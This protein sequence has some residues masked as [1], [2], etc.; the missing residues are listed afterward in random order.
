MVFP[1]KIDILQQWL[2]CRRVASHHVTRAIWWKNEI[3]M[4][5]PD[6]V[7]RPCRNTGCLSPWTAE[8]IWLWVKT[9]AP[10]RYPKIR[11]IFFKWIYIHEYNRLICIYIYKI[12]IMRV[13]NMRHLHISLSLSL[14]LSLHFLLKEFSRDKG[15]LHIYCILGWSFN[16]LLIWGGSINRGLIQFSSISR[17][18][19]PWHKPTS[20]WLPPLL[21]KTPICWSMFIHYIH[22][23]ASLP[24][25]D[26]PHMGPRQAQASHVA[27]RREG[28]GAEAWDPKKTVVQMMAV[29]V[30]MYMSTMEQYKSI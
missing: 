16:R 13:C 17:W 21:W 10:H 12:Y 23:S 9:V 18:D 15:H 27:G 3:G 5:P 30:E 28:L 6:Q 20:Y 11:Y 8:T 7:L 25:G 26:G 1:L 24:P 22:W 4:Q 29:C 19:F 14:Y 2:M